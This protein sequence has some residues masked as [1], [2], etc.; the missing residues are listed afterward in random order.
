M[1][2]AEKNILDR[3]HTLQ[4]K[5]GTHL[6]KTNSKTNWH[7]HRKSKQRKCLLQT[8]QLAHLRQRKKTGHD[9]KKGVTTDVQPATSDDKNQKTEVT[10]GWLLPGGEAEL[11]EAPEDRGVKGSVR[12]ERASRTF[13]RRSAWTA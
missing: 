3:V 1:A 9:R 13:F 12:G 4:K 8:N 11:V 6:S 10:G 7:R 2:I 5:A